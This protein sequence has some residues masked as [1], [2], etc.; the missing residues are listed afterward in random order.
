MILAM[1]YVVTYKDAP[2]EQQ[3]RATFPNKEVAL[4]FA[5]AVEKD[6]GIAL[7][8]SG[9]KTSPTS[10]LPKYVPPASQD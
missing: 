3:Q 6:G 1:E 10:T 5:L 8:T 9:F 2:G 4:A 7:F